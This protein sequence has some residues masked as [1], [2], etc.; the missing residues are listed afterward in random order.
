VA[1]GP[2]AKINVI[3]SRTTKAMTL[4]LAPGEART[5]MTLSLLA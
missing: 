2:V 3:T 4:S 5:N 1:A